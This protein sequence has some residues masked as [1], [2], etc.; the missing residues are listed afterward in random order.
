MSAMREAMPITA[1]WVDELRDSLGRES[2]DAAIAAG[3]KAR[4]EHE[5]LAREFGP[6][7]ADNWLRRQRFP[8]GVFFAKE[9]GHQ[10]GVELP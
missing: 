8:S 4:R 1:G 3:M 6:A 5:R 9:A 7:H 10:V 2:V